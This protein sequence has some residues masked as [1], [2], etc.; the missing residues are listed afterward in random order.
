[1][2]ILEWKNYF[3]SNI[4]LI[5]QQGILYA[6]MAGFHRLPY[7]NVERQDGYLATYDSKNTGTP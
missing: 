4:W 5:K 2:H 6:H 7:I 1:M 3:S